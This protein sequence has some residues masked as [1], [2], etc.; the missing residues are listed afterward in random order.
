MNTEAYLRIITGKHVACPVSIAANSDAPP[1]VSGEGPYHTTPSGKT[2]VHS[3]SAYRWPTVYHAS[4]L[5]ISVGQKWLD[6][7]QLDEVII[8]GSPT[9]RACGLV[10]HVN[11]YALTPSYVSTRSCI[12]V[13]RQGR[14]FHAPRADALSKI[15]DAEAQTAIAAAVAGWAVQDA[16]KIAAKIER[17][18]LASVWVG[19]DHSISAGNCRAGTEYMAAVMRRKLRA[20]GDIG[21]VRADVLLLARDDRFTRRAIAAAMAA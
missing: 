17:E 20:V 14:F 15:I 5:L 13:A 10:R 16:A 9:I 7:M 3:P 19:I 11:G 4:T 2:R 6:R 8:D 21:A 1:T 12:L 18:Q